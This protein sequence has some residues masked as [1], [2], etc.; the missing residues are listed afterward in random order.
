MRNKLVA[1]VA[2]FTLFLLCSLSSNA[3]SNVIAAEPPLVMFDSFDEKVLKA[4]SKSEFESSREQIG[5]T[6][7]IYSHE[8]QNSV[9]L[10]TNTSTVGSV[11]VSADSFYRVTKDNSS[12]QPEKLVVTSKDSDTTWSTN[13]YD[14]MIFR[15]SKGDYSISLLETSGRPVSHSLRL[16]EFPYSGS[17][18]VDKKE[19]KISIELKVRYVDAG[20]T[21]VVYDDKTLNDFL[22]LKTY[23]LDEEKV[24]LLQLPAQITESDGTMRVFSFNKL[25]SSG[26]KPLLGIRDVSGESTNYSIGAFIPYGKGAFLIISPSAFKASEFQLTATL[27]SIGNTTHPVPIY[28]T[29]FQRIEN[30]LDLWLILSLIFVAALIWLVTVS[31]QKEHSMIKKFSQYLAQNLKIQ[32]EIKYLLPLFVFLF[33]FF[34]ITAG[35]SWILF[36]N[37][38]APSWLARIIVSWDISL[39]SLGVSKVFNL[40]SFTLSILLAL[41]FMLELISQRELVPQKYSLKFFT[42]GRQYFHILLKRITLTWVLVA[43]LS[44]TLIIYFISVS[45]E[46][47]GI[48]DSGSTVTLSLKSIKKANPT[49]KIFNGG[50]LSQPSLLS[51]N[52]VYSLRI[53][54]NRRTVNLTVNSDL[55]SQSDIYAEWE[56][57]NQTYGQ[58]IYSSTLE[59][60]NSK[61]ISDSDLTVYWYGDTLSSYH[62]ERLDSVQKINS[63]RIGFSRY[64]LKNT[65]VGNV[66]N[67][68]SKGLSWGDF[69]MSEDKLSKNYAFSDADSEYDFGGI[70]GNFEMYVYLGGNLKGRLLYSDLNKNFGTDDFYVIVLDRNSKIIHSQKIKDDSIPIWSGDSINS[71]SFSVDSITPGLYRILFTNDLEDSLFAN[72]D[73]DKY[74][75]DIAYQSLTINSN[76]LVYRPISK[77]WI[78][79]DKQITQFFDI[80]DKHIQPTGFSSDL[81]SVYKN[82]GIEVSDRFSQGEKFTLNTEDD[83]L[84]RKQLKSFFSLYAPSEESYFYPFSLSIN[85]MS[86]ADSIIITSDKVTLANIRRGEELGVKIFTSDQSPFILF[87]KLDLGI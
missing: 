22:K 30:L 87:G 77:S 81:F 9:G 8:V 24:S 51:D 72:T 39:A 13:F 82:C 14:G 67:I 79:P 55:R 23:N 85:E 15:L 3:A 29:Y 54:F 31:P 47:L 33:I 83:C 10:S 69:Y 66:E 2:A 7:T 73:V 64:A 40:I 63:N 58:L 34:V 49:S 74:N 42:L 27:N 6:E 60:F 71:V 52:I 76:Y 75:P 46:Y 84:S 17:F 56:Y 41:A 26:Y 44:L 80:R 53:P 70:R 21:L 50:A 86:I 11:S 28:W 59:G 1:F 61:A 38:L 18:A 35:S 36:I 78:L 5:F 12:D 68:F 45:V 57:K 62:L 32:K 48:N 16:V 19:L 37:G 25:V 4:I 20:G 65:A 43:G